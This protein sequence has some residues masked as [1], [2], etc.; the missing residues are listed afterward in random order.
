MCTGL[1]R[2]LPFGT[3]HTPAGPS[4]QK[5]E[6]KPHLHAQQQ[7]MLSFQECQSSSPQRGHGIPE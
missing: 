1:R 2:Y 5:L 4:L 3:L 7:S 6:E